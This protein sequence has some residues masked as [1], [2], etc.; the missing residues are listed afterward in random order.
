MD[1]WSLKGKLAFVTGGS[2]GIG[3]SIVEQFLERGA[4]VIFCGRDAESLESAVTQLRTTLQIDSEDSSTTNQKIFALKADISEQSERER[5]CDRVK[6]ISES[7]NL[8]GTL[9]I[10]INN[11]GTNI[12]KPTVE[13]SLQELDKIWRTNFQSCFHLS[14]LFH[15][16][17]KNAGQSSIV[18]ISSVAGGPTS[19]Q[20]GSI[21]GSLKAALNQMT[22]CLAVEWATDGIRVNSVAPW[23]TYTPLAAQVLEKP[24]YLDKV[25]QRTPMQRVGKPEEV[26]AAVSFFCMPASSYITG[27][28]LQVDGGFSVFGF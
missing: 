10:L 6:E 13:Y 4:H 5:L 17:L 14:Q 24:E 27:Q 16:L 25:L 28:T 7:L 19:I 2:K 22:S 8:A 15:P 23:Y 26:A 21:Y 3:F 11:A 18:N 1:L 20:S 9:H 12:R